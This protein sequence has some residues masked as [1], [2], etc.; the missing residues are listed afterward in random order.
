MKKNNGKLIKLQRFH[1]KGE[2]CMIY[3]CFPVIAINSGNHEKVPYN[4]MHSH[5]EN[6]SPNLMFPPKWQN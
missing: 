2:T 3:H 6:Q 4:V 1:L 5:V